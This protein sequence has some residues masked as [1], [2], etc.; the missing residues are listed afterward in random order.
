MF[1]SF[2]QLTKSVGQGDKEGVGRHSKM[3]GLGQDA[4][5]AREQDLTESCNPFTA[6]LLRSGGLV[7]HILHNLMYGHRVHNSG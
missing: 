2:I 4:D 5:V 3:I 1:P 6:E 7:A